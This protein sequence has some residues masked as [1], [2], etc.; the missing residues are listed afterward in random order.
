MSLLLLL[1]LLLLLQ[2]V[3]SAEDIDKGMRLGTNQP[4]GPLRLADFIG[5]CADTYSAGLS[6]WTAC[7]WRTTTAAAFCCYIGCRGKAQHSV[8]S[9]PCT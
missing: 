3:G 2:G 6:I 4:M 1:L 9:G 8:T 7:T 5:A